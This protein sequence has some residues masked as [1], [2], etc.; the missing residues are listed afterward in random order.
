MRNIVLY[1]V[2]VQVNQNKYQALSKYLRGN[3]LNIHFNLP[4]H[5]SNRS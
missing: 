1:F 3:I 4:I 5:S 2:N